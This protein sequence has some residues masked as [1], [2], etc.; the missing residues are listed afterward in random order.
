MDSEEYQ[1]AVEEFNRR[2]MNRVRPKPEASQRASQGV[3]A[4]VWNTM[5]GP[6]E[7]QITGNMKNYDRTDRA[8]ELTTPTLFICGRYDVCTPEETARYHHLVAG[9]EM[10]VLEQSSHS[11]YVEEPERF[12]QVVRDFLRRV[13]ARPGQ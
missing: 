8:H 11:P 4:Q 5:W 10:V 12:L 13:E 7:L 6:Y 1:Q 3:G 2:Y 9:S